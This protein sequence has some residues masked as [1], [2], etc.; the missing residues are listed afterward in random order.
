MHQKQA[1]LILDNFEQVVAASPVVAEL[2]TAS[3]KFKVLVSSRILLQLRAEHE[4]V[5][6][7]LET[8]NT[9]HL[10]ELEQLSQ[11]QSV[12]LFVERAQAN[13]PRFTLTPENAPAVAEICRQLDGL[14]L[15]LELAAARIRLLTPQQ[16]LSRLDHRLAVLT[17]GPRDLPLRHQTLRNSLDLSY[18]LLGEEE[19]ILFSRLGVFVGGFTLEI[20]EA[21]CN[22]AAALDVLDGV[23]SLTNNSLLRSEEGLNGQPRFRMLE[24]SASM[25]WIVWNSAT[26]WRRCKPHML[27]I[28]SLSLLR[29]W[30]SNCTLPI[31]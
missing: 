29:R 24:R 4:V 12:Q 21:V 18:S 13:N 9:A 8:P 7:P 31:P 3:R 22:A 1:L 19:Q 6:P 26:N 14:P 28:T 25:H 16:L 5:V 27:I 15:A 10:P 20:A 23:A 30:A 17:S 2:L 11:N